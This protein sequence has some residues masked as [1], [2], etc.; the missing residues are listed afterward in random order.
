MAEPGHRRDAEDQLEAPANVPMRIDLGLSATP[1]R[2]SATLLP[3]RPLQCYRSNT[4]I[5]GDRPIRH[6]AQLIFPD[7][8]RLG[9]G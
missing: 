2:Y 6:A 1:R 3:L 8:G 7:I 4:H 5:Q 9:L